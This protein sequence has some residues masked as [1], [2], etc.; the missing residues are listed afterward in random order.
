MKRTTLSVLMAFLA[1]L[2]LAVFLMAQQA[3][4]LGQQQP[5]QGDQP[6][7]SQP[8]SAQ[9]AQPAPSTSA[10]QSNSAQSSDESKPGQSATDK[11]MPKTASNLPLVALLGVASLG[12]GVAAHRYSRRYGER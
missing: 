3:A 9:Q 12:A 5:D 1:S 10:D 7:A 2:A 8:D 4:P 6:A 11:Q